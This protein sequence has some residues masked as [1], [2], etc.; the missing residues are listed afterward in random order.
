M[1]KSVAKS[2]SAVC[3]VALT[4]LLAGGFLLAQSPP[5]QGPADQGKEKKGDAPKKLS[6]LEEMLAR[7]LKNNPD[8]H[9]AESK[10]REA[11]AELNRTRLQVMQKVVALQHAIDVQKVAVEAAA[12][13][14][15]R[16]DK[17][18]KMGG[19][20]TAEELTKAQQAL[21]GARAK[22]AEV[23][24]QLP[25]LLGKQPLA[26]KAGKIEEVAF[27]PDGRVLYSKSI[28]G[29]IRVWDASSG[30]ELSP[31][32][33]YVRGHS[34]TVKLW[35]IVKPVQGTMAE[36]IRAALDT[37]V[38]VNF[39]G[40]GAKVLEAL[41]SRVKGVYFQNSS[42]GLSEKG[43]ELK[44]ADK[45]PV[46]AV[47]QILEDS[48]PGLRFVVRDYG[49]LGTDKEKVPP[50]AMSM[51]DFWKGDKGEAKSSKDPPKN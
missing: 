16:L 39:E 5:P 11:E 44:M 46:G 41:Q 40:D 48:V 15:A 4:F 14:F 6:P 3:G 9:V 31:L 47:L 26:G 18:K 20:L 29:A 8:I 1:S 19:A 12:A 23:E 37:P 38:N 43:F 45:L 35:D 50:G 25:F 24:A 2:A 10:V 36:K 17:L 49:I 27:S 22:L 33:D 21:V 32:H 7:A 34:G 42:T 30:K 28:E 51:R 13:D